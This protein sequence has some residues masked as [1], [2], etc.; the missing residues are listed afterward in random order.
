MAY[1]VEDYWSKLHI[2]SNN[3]NSFKIEEYH[4][5]CQQ[6]KRERKLKQNK[7]Q[8]NKNQTPV[9]CMISQNVIALPLPRGEKKGALHSLR[10]IHL[11]ENMI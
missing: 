7:K 2:S 4:L 3:V 8:T 9:G 6:K 5:K 11:V 10:L 1:I